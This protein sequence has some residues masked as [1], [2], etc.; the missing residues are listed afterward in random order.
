MA[1]WQ[2]AT[3]R[4]ESRQVF[5]R[6]TKVQIGPTSPSALA[7]QWQFCEQYFLRTAAGEFGRR[8]AAFASCCRC[9]AAT[10][11]VCNP[12]CTSVIPHLRTVFAQAQRTTARSRNLLKNSALHRGIFGSEMTSSAIDHG[13]AGAVTGIGN[14]LASLRRFWAVA[15]RIN[16][17]FAPYGP[18]NRRRPKPSIR[19][20]CAN[21]I[22]TFFRS[23]I[24]MT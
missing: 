8:L 10:L 23:R 1:E 2:S 14:V 13:A 17:S 12:P 7:P 18:R 6:H 3:S 16:S 24:A 19:F 9:N 4:R 5:P 22:S 15:A 11:S 20:R 21:S